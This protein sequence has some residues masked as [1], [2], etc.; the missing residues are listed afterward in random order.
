MLNQHIG[1]PPPLNRMMW[2]SPSIVLMLERLLAKN[3]EDRFAN[4]TETALALKQ[5]RERLSS[6]EEQI[7]ETKR[8]KPDDERPSWTTTSA[9]AGPG[10]GSLFPLLALIAALCVAVGAWYYLREFL[11]T[12]ELLPSTAVV[13][14][15]TEHLSIG[16]L[17]FVGI[18]DQDGSKVLASALQRDVAAGLARLPGMRVVEFD[19][20]RSAELDSLSLREIGRELGVSAL[21]E[22]S[23]RRDPSR[24]RISVHLVDPAT[25]QSLWAET[26]DRELSTAGDVTDEISG[27]VMRG[28]QR[29]RP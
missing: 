21:L 17:P 18:G 25:G 20:A 19:P 16:I 29:A 28:L 7:D 1:R 9:S 22:A 2:L 24:T 27:G 26:F 11:A 3:P 10:L 5:C 14:S 4:A 12:R 13:Q 23:V 6:C 8:P 15:S